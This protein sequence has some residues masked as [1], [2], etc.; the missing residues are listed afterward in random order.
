MSQY[1]YSPE[2]YC[3]SINYINNTWFTTKSDDEKITFIADSYY[4][5]NVIPEYQFILTDTKTGK[6]KVIRDYST[7]TTLTIEEPKSNYKIR[8]NAREKGSDVE[9][10]RYYEK[11][12]KK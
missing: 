5:S 12:V 9:Y 7:D 6:S 4:G 8:L 3:K 11:E 1:F 2:E 10:S